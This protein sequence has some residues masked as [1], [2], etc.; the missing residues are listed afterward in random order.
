MAWQNQLSHLRNFSLSSKNLTNLVLPATAFVQMLPKP[1]GS[2][3]NVSM[4]SLTLCLLFWRDGYVIIPNRHRSVFSQ[5]MIKLVPTLFCGS[6]GECLPLVEGE[7]ILSILLP[8]GTCCDTP[9]T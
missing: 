7:P 9:R 4:V 5:T 1:S 6:M 3:L 8:K 2:G